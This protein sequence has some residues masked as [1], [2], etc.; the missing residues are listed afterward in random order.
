M[1]DD[2]AG[3]GIRSDLAARE[4]P[5]TPRMPSGGK[6]VAATAAAVLASAANAFLVTSIMEGTI[7]IGHVTSVLAAYMTGD[8][9]GLL[10]VMMAA[11]YVLPL[12]TGADE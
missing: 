6:R 7:R 8:I 4:L 12:V 5:A 2:A 3:P 9:T 11:K 10:M 1:D